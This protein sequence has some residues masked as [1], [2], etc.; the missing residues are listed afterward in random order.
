MTEKRLPVFRLEKIKT[1]LAT[2]AMG[3]HWNRTQPTPNADTSMPDGVQV[4]CG[5]GNPDQDMQPFLDRITGP[6]RK[7]EVIGIEALM[8]ASE[9]MFRRPDQPEGSRDPE[10]VKAWSDAAMKCL[11][12]QFPDMVASAVLHLDETTP[13]IHALIVPVVEKERK[14]RGR[15][16]KDKPPF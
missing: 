5:T 15:G 1:S 7:D 8:S 14:A 6:R 4:L 13:H 10:R 12:E 16:A 3:R 11:R 9:D 2:K